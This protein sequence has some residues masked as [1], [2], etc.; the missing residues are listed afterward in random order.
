MVPVQC[1]VGVD[2]DDGLPGD[3]AEFA[4]GQV[5]GAGED[6]VLHG[7]GVFGGQGLAVVGDDPGFGPVQGS[8]FEGVQGGGQVTGHGLGVPDP[9]TGGDGGDP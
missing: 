2:G 7:D 8:V 3:L 1:T 9:D 6:E 5:A 4:G